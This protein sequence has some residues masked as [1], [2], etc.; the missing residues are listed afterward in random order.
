MNIIETWSFWLKVSVF[1]PLFIFCFIQFGNHQEGHWPRLLIQSC[2]QRTP[3]LRPRLQFQSLWGQVSLLFLLHFSKYQSPLSLSSSPV[4]YTKLIT[5][6]VT[7]L[8]QKEA[9]TIECPPP[10]HFPLFSC[11]VPYVGRSF[12]D[13]VS[14]PEHRRRRWTAAAE[15]EN[16]SQCRGSSSPM[17]SD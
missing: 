10:P 7:M 15:G 14:Q 1:L 13:D 3:S 2:S 16:R 9:W 17:S 11:Q 4:N 12:P 5:H 6:I 8:A